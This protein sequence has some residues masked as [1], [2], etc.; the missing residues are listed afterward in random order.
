MITQNYQVTIAG[1]QTKTNIICSKFKAFDCLSFISSVIHALPEENPKSSSTENFL[2]SRR[3]AEYLIMSVM[4][5]GSSIT[6]TEDEKK[7]YT[8]L[9]QE[10]DFFASVFKKSFI[11]SSEEK[12]KEFTQK[13]LSLY[14]Y[15]NQPLDETS[16][17]MFF[18]DP[19]AL[20]GALLHAIRY[21]Y[22][23]F[24]IFGEH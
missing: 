19:R 6:L 14:T 23:D 17:Y 15:N 16:E 11:N 2:L 21:N 3:G 20:M 9:S 22:N 12:Q 7:N 10:Q 5:T 8:D 18:S 24:F 13:L 4:D 1:Q